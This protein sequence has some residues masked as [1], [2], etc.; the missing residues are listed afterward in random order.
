M[1]HFTVD[2]RQD[3]VNI[4]NDDV[5]FNENLA[6]N[7]PKV[8]RSDYDCE[9]LFTSA[10]RALLL[11][12]M[13]NAIPVLA[14]E[15][16]TSDLS[17]ILD[18]LNVIYCDTKATAQHCK[19][20]VQVLKSNDYVDV[21]SP[22]HNNHLK[23]KILKETASI[24]SGMPINLI[25]SYYGDGVAFFFAWMDFMTKWFMIPGLLGLVVYFIRRARGD[26]VDNCDFTPF[27]GLATFFWAIFC[28]RCWERRESRLAFLWGSFASTH[29]ERA[30]FGQRPEFEGYERKSPVTGRVEKYYPSRKRLMKYAGSALVTSALLIGAT[31]VMVIGMNIQ[32]YISSEDLEQW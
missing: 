19:S 3:F 16:E 20:L 25:Q 21:I 12:S 18:S 6:E 27:V 14:Q 7:L 23:E 24:K 29:R 30:S 1:E 8:D 2:A 4:E 5:C 22:V 10:D 17:K 32:G 15:E 31:F 9:G 28:D 13:L 11:L 26:T